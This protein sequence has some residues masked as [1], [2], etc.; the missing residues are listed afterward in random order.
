M[1]CLSDVGW[2]DYGTGTLHYNW[3]MS[4]HA[5]QAF[6][7]YTSARDC[8]NSEHL[9]VG[10]ISSQKK[11]MAVLDTVNNKQYKVLNNTCPSHRAT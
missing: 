8:I 7:M 5:S 6:S 4:A 2:K 9:A 10:H 3:P 11:L 1:V